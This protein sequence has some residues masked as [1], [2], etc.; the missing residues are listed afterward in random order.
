MAGLE[1]AAHSQRTDGGQPGLRL[2]RRRS[3]HRDGLRFGRR[4]VRCLHRHRG[5]RRD[6]SA[7]EPRQQPPR[8]ATISTTCWS[9]YLEAEFHDRIA[10]RW[11]TNIAPRGRVCGGPPKTAKKTLSSEP[12]A[13]I[14]EEAL[15]PGGQAAAPGPRNLT[16]RVRGDDSCRWWSRRSTACPKPLTMRA[17]RPAIWT[18]SCWSADLLARRWFPACSA[19]APGSIR[20]RTCIPILRGL[21]AG[22]LASRLA[23]R[24]RGAR[25]GGCLALFVWPSYLGE[26]GGV[27]YPHCYHP[28]SAATRRCR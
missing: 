22:V 17:R 25:A 15:I 27:P 14:R 5:R 1:V 28:S 26:R 4:H 13:R 12:Y 18:R 23:G 6:R 7:V 9:G 3:P 11:A 2:R 20:A 24:E 21:G 10:F 8:A 19:S 16:R